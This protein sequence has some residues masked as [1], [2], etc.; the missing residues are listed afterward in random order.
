[1]HYINYWGGQNYITFLGDSRIRQLY[2]EFVNLLSKK[3]VVEEKVHGD[4]HYVDKKI[5]VKVV[6]LV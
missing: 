5:R 1:M 2:Y 4:L 3:K 6:S